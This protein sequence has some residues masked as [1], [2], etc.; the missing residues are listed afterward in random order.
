MSA[1]PEGMR[2]HFIQ[3]KVKWMDYFFRKLGSEA[4]TD[5]FWQERH[6]TR[7]TR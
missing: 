7:S 5:M 2:D 3:S 4:R 6:T 1:I